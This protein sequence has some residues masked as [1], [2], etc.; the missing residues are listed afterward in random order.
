MFFLAKKAFLEDY[1]EIY[2]RKK[3]ISGNNIK[4][5]AA[6]KGRRDE[7]ITLYGRNVFAEGIVVS[8]RT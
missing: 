5:K 1:R 8:I 4:E 3:G 6:T 2:G 7:R